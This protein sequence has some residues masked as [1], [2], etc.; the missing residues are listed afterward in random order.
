LEENEM[1]EAVIVV[2]MLNDFVYGKLACDRALDIIPNIRSLLEAARRNGRPVIFA[3]DAH[4]PTDPEMRLW[5]EHAMKGTK[6]AEVIPEL[7][8]EPQDY[9]LEKRNYSSFFETGLELLLH[10]LDVDTV[11]ITGLH[12]HMCC[13]HTAA[14]AF[15][16]GFHVIGA[17]DCLNAFTDEDHKA[18]LDYLKDVYAA[19][20]TDGSTLAEEWDRGKEAVA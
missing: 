10:T 15:M 1:K 16:R 8:P 4:L 5:G 13:R 17:Q 12:T 6:E 11:V 20:I 3:N 2:D 19:R 7:Q 14:D 9:I 18:G